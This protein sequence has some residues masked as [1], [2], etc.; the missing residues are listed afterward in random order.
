MH[1]RTKRCTS[2]WLDQSPKNKTPRERLEK[3]A[4]LGVTSRALS[5]NSRRCL[6]L[7]IAGISPQSATSPGIPNRKENGEGFTK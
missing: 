2:S 4:L 7:G 5:L 1:A 6:S 3:A